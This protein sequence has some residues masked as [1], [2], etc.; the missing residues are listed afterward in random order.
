MQNVTPRAP[1]RSTLCFHKAQNWTQK[2]RTL[3]WWKAMQLSL[4]KP[5]KGSLLGLVTKKWVVE[6]NSQDFQSQ[7]RDVQHEESSWHTLGTGGFPKMGVDSNASSILRCKWEKLHKINKSSCVYLVKSKI[8]SQDPAQNQNFNDGLYSLGRRERV[9]AGAAVGVCVCVHA[10]VCLCMWM[11]GW[12]CVCVCL[13]RGVYMCMF[14][15]LLVF[16]RP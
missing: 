11:C 7:I 2:V 1:S 9:E 8:K 4:G 6:R 14:L 5:I 13:W 12:V 16:S 15:W 3:P 10:C